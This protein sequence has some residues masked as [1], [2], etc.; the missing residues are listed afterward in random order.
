MNPAPPA[1]DDLAELR[2]AAAGDPDGWKA[3]LERHRERL[4]RL[5]AFRLDRRLWGRVDPSD[6]VQE[7]AFE[8]AR[9]LPEFLADPA[10]P[11]FLWLRF[12]TTQRLATVHRHHLGRELRDA[13]RD[14]PLDADAGASSGAIAAR[15]AADDTGPS[16]AA[17][18]AER[19]DRLHAAL[20]VMDPIDREVLALRHFEGLS[21]AE[22]AI[23][24]DLTV[25]AAS[26]RYVRAVERLRTI[27][28]G[29]TGN[30]P[31]PG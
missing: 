24:L 15:L 27:L 10:V 29:L 2:R 14:V 16:T 17:V 22:T 7:V 4:R 11:V 9:R 18:R 30:T 5:A 6:V 19:A 20:D 8:A 23:A 31:G 13:A 12:L 3:V 25:S 21:N 1:D 28:D 26:K